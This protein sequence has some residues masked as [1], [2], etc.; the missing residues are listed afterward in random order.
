MRC[1][2]CGASGDNSK[3]GCRTVSTSGH[4]KAKVGLIQDIGTLPAGGAWRK[5][6]LQVC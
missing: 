6:T 2:V 4:R 5:E 1:Q 3:K